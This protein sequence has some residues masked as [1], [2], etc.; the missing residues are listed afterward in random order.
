MRRGGPP[1]SW[2]GKEIPIMLLG[3]YLVWLVIAFHGR[4]IIMLDHALTFDHWW[5]FHDRLREG[6][7][8]Q[9][10]P[11]SLLGRIAVQWGYVPVS[12]M[13]PALV[14]AD[15]NLE[16]FRHFTILGNCLVLLSVYVLGRTTGYGRYLSLLPVL[17]IASSGFR[18]WAAFLHFATFLTVYPLAVGYLISFTDHG[19]RLRLSSLARLGMLLALACLGL[20]AE[21]MVYTF[22]FVVL[23]FASLGLFAVPGPGRAAWAVGGPGLV[24]FAAGASAWQIA[25]L[26][27]STLESARFA[28]GVNLARL[29]D[30]D[31]LGWLLRAL[32]FQPALLLLLLNLVLRAATRKSAVLRE[33]RVSGLALLLLLTA[34][35]GGAQALGWEMS[36]LATSFDGDVGAEV[37][38]IVRNFDVFVTPAGLLAI[39][40]AAIVFLRGE[41]APALP[42]VFAFAA[43]LCSGFAVTTY[44][45]HIW[46]VNTVFHSYFVPA[47]LTGLPAIGAVGLW[48]AGR[49]WILATL[50][51]YH[52]I[53][54]LGAFV[55]SEVF[56]IPWLPPRAAFAEM[57]LQMILALEAARLLAG[58]AGSLVTTLRPGLE[59]HLRRSSIR[60][61]ASL[62]CVLLVGAGMSLALFPS[63]VVAE[64]EAFPFT[65]GAREISL[66]NGSLEQWR[67]SLDGRLVPDGY[68]YHSGDQV[69]RLERVS[70][71]GEVVSG[72]AAACLTPGVTGDSWLRY[73]VP[74]VR[75]LKGHYVRF[76][77]WMKDRAVGDGV[78]VDLQDGVS[79]IVY[80]RSKSQV[81]PAVSSGHWQARSIVSYVDPRARML[82]W[83]ANATPFAGGMACVDDLRLEVTDSSPPRHWRDVDDFPYRRA[84]ASRASKAGGAWLEEALETSLRVRAA[85]E[86]ARD[87]FHR[88]RVPDS[89]LMF[90]SS[91]QY[92]K[93]LPAYSRT[94]NTAPMYSS[95]IPRML[96]PLLRAG[97][98]PETPGSTIIHPEMG[99]LL[100]AYKWQRRLQNE[101]E[102]LPYPA[103]VTI[104]PH[105]SESHLTLDLLAEEGRDTPR[106]YLSRRIVP[107]PDSTAER[108]YLIDVLARG[109]LVSD[110]ITTS[111]PT[112]RTSGGGP[113]GTVGDVTF[114]S[115]DPERVTLDVNVEADAYL[116]LLDL[117]SP[118]WRARVDGRDKPIYRG[119]VGTRF[120]VVPAGR[121]TV[122]FTYTVPG[123]W[124]A[125][126]ISLLTWTIGIAALV[127]RRPR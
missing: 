74:D 112:F 111:D 126:W 119:Y 66:A 50:V 127:T 18:Y 6:Q 67:A 14:V 71:P 48:L 29:L 103:R 1:W 96:Y 58:L 73:S 4:E 68:Q 124:P 90:T 70:G 3:V 24:L 116:A 36:R 54:E 21:L 51:A 72:Q 16:R 44:T 99:P 19:R 15:L 100:R 76:S 35:I 7:L 34:Q 11:F 87:H 64:L 114:R 28:P 5:Y 91:E 57:P 49:T 82:L 88:V 20:R 33:R 93:F 31:L 25:F 89:I 69:A 106:A 86:R 125:T 63:E 2:L 84:S 120:V 109:G 53:G 39:L 60:M 118:G 17:L 47:A 27:T 26:L 121:H 92:Y 123:L 78:Q 97:A 45:G 95:E 110:Q 108:Q 41:P 10:N 77:Y 115:D 8:A 42:R 102:L 81:P 101:G 85:S 117:W 9:W 40:A 65:T 52:A 98:P 61:M 80:E 12:L 83:T 94:L 13:T 107:L 75:P 43:A 22:V 55:L 32:A 56:G 23:V 38:P 113:A 30:P 79:P 62:A 122:E 104:R 46:P 59:A 37:V 105:Q